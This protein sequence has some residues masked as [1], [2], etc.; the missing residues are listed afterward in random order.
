MYRVHMLLPVT[1]SVAWKGRIESHF[2]NMA[3]KLY[4]QKAT[5]LKFVNFKPKCHNFLSDHRCH[6]SSDRKQSE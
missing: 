5:C 1:W 2:P 6:R 4:H 3:N